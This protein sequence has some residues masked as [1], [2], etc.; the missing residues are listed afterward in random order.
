MST[1][2][3]PIAKWTRHLT[4]PR[5]IEV[6]KILSGFVWIQSVHYKLIFCKFCFRKFKL[7]RLF[8]LI[9]SNK[10]RS[11]SFLWQWIQTN[12]NVSINNPLLFAKLR[13]R[14]TWIA[15]LK[16]ERKAKEANNSK[17]EPNWRWCDAITSENDIVIGSCGQ[18]RVVPFCTLLSV[19]SFAIVTK[20]R[21]KDC[22]AVC[23]SV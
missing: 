3:Q 5:R 15:I 4:N 6:K 9:K 7:G 10:L 23:A 17:K 16:K 20:Q 21:K 13:N 19:P 14:F 1:S 11:N 8:W 22:V 18:T 2:R 12:T